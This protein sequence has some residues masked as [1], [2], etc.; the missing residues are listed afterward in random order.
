MRKQN[1]RKKVSRRP[2]GKKAIVRSALAKSWKKSVASVC[3]RVIARQA[4]V[5]TQE[6]RTNVSPVANNQ[7]LATI[8]DQN[9]VMISP[10]SS[11]A[12]ISQSTNSAGRIGNEV[13]TKFCKGR[14]ILYPKAYNLSNNSTPCPTVV[15]VWCVSS[16]L[17]YIS[18]DNLATLFTSQFFQYGASSSGY[19][20]RLED[21]IQ[22]IN[23]DTLQVHFK[24]TYKVGHNRQEGNGVG[25][26]NGANDSYFN[27]N[28]YKMNHIINYD[29]TKFMRKIYKFNDAND[30]AQGKNVWL[31]FGVA[32]ADGSFYSATNYSPLDVYL[33][34]QYG[35]T[36]M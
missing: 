17:G 3:K 24:R 25:P 32:K 19:L 8:R 2:K 4:E 5:K 28:D 12:T 36:D 16:K 34:V 11:Y 9:L 22:S 20:S 18:P 23:K 33:Q 21:N 7:S 6:L 10:A 27:N 35:Y 26:S 15:T 30:T 14:M 1:Y 29:F 31:V 13:Y